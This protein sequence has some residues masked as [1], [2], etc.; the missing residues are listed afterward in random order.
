MDTAGKICANSG[1]VFNY[2]NHSEEFMY[3]DSGRKI[4][5]VTPRDK[6]MRKI[7]AGPA[8]PSAFLQDSSCITYLSYL[9]AI[10]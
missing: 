8:Q 4:S 10:A 2:H 1:L 6:R 9:K 3:F 5:R 7:Y